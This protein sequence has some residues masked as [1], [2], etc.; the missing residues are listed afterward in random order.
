MPHGDRKRIFN[1]IGKL[2]SG[3]RFWRVEDSEVGYLVVLF[4]VTLL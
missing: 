2:D 3:I 4:C 1:V